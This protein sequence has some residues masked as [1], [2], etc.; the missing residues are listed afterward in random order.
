M[1]CS[2]AVHVKEMHTDTIVSVESE[3]L[4]GL[5]PGIVETEDL[6]WPYAYVSRSKLQNQK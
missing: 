3:I 4:K 1:S 6:L 5:L 2:A